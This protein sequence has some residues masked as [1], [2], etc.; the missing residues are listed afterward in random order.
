MAEALTAALVKAQLAF[1]KIERNRTV[2]VKTQKGKYE[3]KYATLDTIIDAIRKPLA[4]NGLSFTQV[5][6]IDEGKPRLITRLMHESG[7]CIES[8]SPILCSSMGNQEFGSALSYMRRYA[9]SSLLGIATQEDDDAN[10]DSGNHMADKPLKASSKPSTAKE[11]SEAP[12]TP[13][14]TDKQ[15]KFAWKLAQEVGWD[16]ETVKAEVRDRYSV[17][18]SK[19]LTKQQASDLIEHLQAIKEADEDE[20]VDL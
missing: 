4:D 20:E 9:L 12:S 17:E 6:T 5:M 10:I 2:E 1:P 13:N 18:T 19:E 11:G 16:A 14:A 3:F 15:L 7:E 8:M